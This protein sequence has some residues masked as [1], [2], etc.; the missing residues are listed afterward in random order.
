MPVTEIK[1][2]RN[3][4]Q[5]MVD[6]AEN[7]TYTPVGDI[8]VTTLI[9]SPRIRILKKHCNYTEDVS[10][11]VW[12]IFGTATH[13]IIERACENNKEKYWSEV[14]LEWEVGGVKIGGT[15][16]LYDKE[17][18]KLHDF[19][20]TS[21]WSIIFGDRIISWTKQLNIYM[22]LLHKTFPDMEV[23]EMS[24]ITLLKDWNESQSKRDGDYPKSA[25]EEIPIKMG[26]ID[27]I[28]K[29]IEERITLHINE[30]DVY[31]S[32]GEAKMS[33]CTEDERWAKPTKYAVRKE[34]RKTALRVLDTLVDADAWILEKGSPGEKLTIEVRKGEDVRCLRYCPVKE[35]CSYYKN[36]YE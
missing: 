22:Y 5:I 30:E 20:V 15:L 35:F 9:D 21:V 36:T 25:I 29:F 27:K 19:K 10:E 13:S 31:N 17:S 1:N 34:G 14:S 12:S 26:K 33:V 24:I 8:G 3:L 11:L 23:K 18:K 7:D 32:D 28:E 6:V 16:D 2:K 4:P